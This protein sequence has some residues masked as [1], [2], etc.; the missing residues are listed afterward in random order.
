MGESVANHHDEGSSAKDEAVAMVGEVQ[1]TVDPVVQ[2]RA[3]RK[4]DWFLMP[5]MICG[6]EFLNKSFMKPRQKEPR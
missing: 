1:H 2:A 3:V 6:C 5:A 4:I